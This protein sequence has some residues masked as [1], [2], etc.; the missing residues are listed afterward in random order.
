MPQPSGIYPADTGDTHHTFKFLIVPLE[1]V[2]TNFQRYG[3]LDNQV[4]FLVGWFK[5]TLPS[6]PITQLSVMRLDG[7]MYES[8]MDA[9][10]NL[11]PKLSIGGYAIIDDYGCIPSC[12][13]AVHD[14][15]LKNNITDEIYAIDGT[16]VYWKRS[17]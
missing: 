7:D 16:S 6:A 13:M 11:Y 17:K 1:Q 8:T 4:Q 3:L 9:L 5:D 14:F 12:K 15:R 2:K 10:T